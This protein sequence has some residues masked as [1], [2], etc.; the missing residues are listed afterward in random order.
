MAVSGGRWRGGVDGQLGCE[1][2]LVEIESLGG[3]VTGDEEV[4]GDAGGGAFI[5]RGFGHGASKSLGGA[6]TNSGFAGRAQC[7]GETRGAGPGRMGR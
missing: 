5:A 1:G 2:A 4:R 3:T 6:E 7:V